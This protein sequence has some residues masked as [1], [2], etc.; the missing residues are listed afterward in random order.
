MK[1]Y[2]FK[3]D[4]Y[5]GNCYVIEAKNMREAR[6]QL[7]KVMGKILPICYELVFRNGIAETNWL[8]E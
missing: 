1:L 3:Y 6:R 8:G 2:F 7:K 4:G 5:G